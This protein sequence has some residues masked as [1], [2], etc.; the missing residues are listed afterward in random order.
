[1]EFRLSLDDAKS[2]LQANFHQL[3]EILSPPEIYTEHSEILEAKFKGT[4]HTPKE[5]AAFINE[6]AEV[7]FKLHVHPC[8]LLF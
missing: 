8:R 6:P 5:P 3:K 2:P 1:M 4:V 7:F